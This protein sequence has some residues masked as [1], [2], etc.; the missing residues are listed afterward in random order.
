MSFYANQ[1]DYDTNPLREAIAHT[2]DSTAHFRAV[3]DQI[4]EKL[5]IKTN[6]AGQP[7]DKR[8]KLILD[9]DCHETA[10]PKTLD[11]PPDRRKPLPGTITHEALAKH[12][13]VSPASLQRYIHM[14]RFAN[15][16]P[17]AGWYRRRAGVKGDTVMP[18][19]RKSEVIAYLLDHDHCGARRLLAGCGR[20]PK[21]NQT[22]GRRA[23]K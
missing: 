5:G 18:C 4:Y 21:Y 23:A 8:G 16:L 11:V 9:D 6:A 14:W 17:V 10:R 1:E 19:Y 15:P 22:R 3:R 13:G 7:V 12:F 2:P 20:A